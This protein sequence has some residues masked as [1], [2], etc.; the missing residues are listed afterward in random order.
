RDPPTPRIYTLSYTTLFRSTR[1]RD[2]DET[3]V[4]Y[5]NETLIRSV[6]VSRASVC[7]VLPLGQTMQP[8]T[9]RSAH[10][11]ISLPWASRP[12]G[13][14]VSTVTVSP[15][16]IAGPASRPPQPTAPGPRQ[17]RADATAPSPSSTRPATP[18]GRRAR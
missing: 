13:E 5:G 11:Q 8:A 9:S 18:P 6:T 16:V 2:T 7:S 10:V 14:R 15:L 1:I 12:A 3:S 4:P 17:G